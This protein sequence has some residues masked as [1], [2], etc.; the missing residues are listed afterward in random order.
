MLVVEITVL[1][2]FGVA[3]SAQDLQG[4]DVIALG[5]LG[6]H[7][8]VAPL[9]RTKR[10]APPVKSR[11]TVHDGLALRAIL[12]VPGALLRGGGLL[13]GA[14]GSH[15]V[16]ST[17][18]SAWS[19]LGAAGRPGSGH[20]VAAG[21]LHTLLHSLRLAESPAIL[22]VACAALHLARVGSLTAGRGARPPAASLPLGI[23]KLGLARAAHNPVIRRESRNLIVTL[24]RLLAHHLA[25]W[26]RALLG[27]LALPVADWLRADSLALQG[28]VAQ[29]AALRLL[30]P[31]LA[32]WPLAVE[33]LAPFADVFGA[34]HFA[35]GWRTLHLAGVQVLFSQLGASR[36]ALGPVALGLAVLLADGLCAIPGAVWQAAHALLIR[37]NLPV[38]AESLPRDVR[39]M[40]ITLVA[41]HLGCFGDVRTDRRLRDLLGGRRIQVVLILVGN[42]NWHP[43]IAQI[44]FRA[45]DIDNLPESARGADRHNSSFEQRHARCGKPGHPTQM[46]DCPP[47]VSTA[48]DT[49]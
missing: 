42:R 22:L 7:V 44:G 9:A 6:L 8:R 32:F 17:R 28:I 36:L 26:L 39:F 33:G 37:N 16:H 1:E 23:S 10:Q 40:I 30:A 19:A 14:L 46:L 48:V 24:R 34:E 20:P 43:D 5:T 11:P 25:V 3:E 45:T 29:E 12:A 31:R 47:Q 21:G 2:D 18:A 15:A 49:V 27:L 35:L 38:R 4:R 13:A 41:N